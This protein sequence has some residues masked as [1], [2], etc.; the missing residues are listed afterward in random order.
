LTNEAIKDLNELRIKEMK[1]NKEANREGLHR[2]DLNIDK[3]EEAGIEK[4]D[5]VLENF[6][7]NMDHLFL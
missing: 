2:N 7:K 1:V 3:L 6:C 4:I 5:E